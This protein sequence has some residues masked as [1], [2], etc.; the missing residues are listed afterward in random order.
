MYRKYFGLIAVL[1]FL[2]HAF[3][4]AAD[5]GLVINQ[6]TAIDS[7]DGKVADPFMDGFEYR[8]DILPRASFLFGDTGEAFLSAGFSLGIKN[9]D[10]IYIPELLR[11][12]VYYD[13]GNMGIRAGRMQ[14]ADP[15]GF[16]AAG[17]FDGARF[18]YNSTMGSFGIGAWYTGLL[19]KKNANITMTPEEQINFYTPV[20]YDD[21]IN[22]YFAPKRL[23]VSLDWE[24]PSIAD[25]LRLS[26]AILGQVDFNNKYHSQ[27]A[28]IK[29]SVP[30]D[31]LVLEF[32]GSFEMAEYP[33]DG[34]TKFNTAFA[35]DLGIYWMPPTVFN[36]RLS[37]TGR[38]LSGYTSD[39]LGV[40]V[41]VSNKFYGN[42]L[43]ARPQGISMFGLDY[44]ARLDRSLGASLNATYFMRNDLMTYME[45]WLIDEEKNT[46]HLLGLEL[47]ARLVWSPFSD[48]QFFLGGGAFLPS[49]GD[50]GPKVK[51][52][53]HVEL[54][55]ILALY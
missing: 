49:L 19:Y 47:F 8:T 27:Y 5:F 9:D 16:I 41:P 14:Y 35:W 29:A 22:T 17:L 11:T 21:F 12:D 6:Y 33:V 18:S 30:V 2:P 51:P 7:Q 32:G 24:H 26:A 38:F 31:S 13:F 44:T 52:R 20:E 1:L 54:S 53:W 39:T 45:D 3:L 28:A 43:K 46:G 15:L 25:R 10:F 37:L 36:S 48:L 34:D 40:F 42:V 4:C 23:L 55:A 50:A